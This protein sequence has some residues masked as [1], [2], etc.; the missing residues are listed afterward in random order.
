[1]FINETQ[2]R[3]SGF[4]KEE[5]MGKSPLVFLHPDD[6][7]VATKTFRRTLKEGQGRGQFRMR[8]KDNSYKWMDA[9]ARVTSDSEGN[10]RI[11]MVSRDITREKEIEQKLK[12]AEQKYGLLAKNI[13]DIIWTMDLNFNTT[14]ASPSVKA[15]IGYTVEED[16]SRSITDKFTPESLKKITEMIKKH[17]TPK[18]IKIKI[19]IPCFE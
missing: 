5:I 14:Y 15:I 12:E 3:I 8:S 7:K 11:L 16:L 17:I 6:I 10:R 4:S 2:E 1:M 9:N 18:N 19:I 13:N